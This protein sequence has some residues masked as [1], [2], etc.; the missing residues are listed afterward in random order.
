MLNTALPS[1]LMST[2]LYASWRIRCGRSLTDRPMS[3]HSVELMLKRR[4][5]A[6]GLPE[7]FSPHSFRVLVVTNPLSQNVPPR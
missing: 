3:L 7:I 1:G 4:L 2:Q 5:K 6:A